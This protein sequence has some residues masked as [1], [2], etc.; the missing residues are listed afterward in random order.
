MIESSPEIDKTS[1]G[2]EPKYTACTNCRQRKRR[3]T[4]KGDDTTSSNAGEP[5][6][7]LALSTRKSFIRRS[8]AL[9]LQNPSKEMTSKAARSQNQRSEALPAYHKSR[10][11]IDLESPNDKMNDM[12]T[13]TTSKATKKE[14]NNIGTVGQAARGA[15]AQ[16]ESLR[17]EQAQIKQ[18]PHK[19]GLTAAHKGG[20][21]SSKTMRRDES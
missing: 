1:N 5:L 20:R 17:S 18:G 16:T 15:L 9:A 3:C 19:Q 2:E 8:R 21:G 13:S 4:H 12:A 14:R 6:K 11:V 10:I 7:K